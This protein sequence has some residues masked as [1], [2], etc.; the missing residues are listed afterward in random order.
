[1]NIKKEASAMKDKVQITIDAGN[2]RRFL[3]HIECDN[4]AI[5]YQQGYIQNADGC[6]IY[7]APN[8]DEKRVF[9]YE[10]STINKVIKCLSEVTNQP[11]VVTFGD[12]ITISGIQFFNDKT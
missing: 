1:M 4:T 11:I 6:A 3:K 9:T 10:W 7:S 2:F 12:S 5:T 8:S